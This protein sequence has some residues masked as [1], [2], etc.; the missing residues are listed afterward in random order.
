MSH[1]LVLL[2]RRDLKI[3]KYEGNFTYGLEAV[4]WTLGEATVEANRLSMT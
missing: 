3:L 2:E 4:S 1:D